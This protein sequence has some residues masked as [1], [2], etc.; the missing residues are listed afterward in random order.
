MTEDVVRHL[1]YLTLGTRLKR[2]GE[3]MQADVQR[4]LAAN[5]VGVPVAQFPFLAAIDRLGP[6]TIGELARAVG[7][8]QPG[9]TRAVEQLVAAELLVDQPS[10]SD[11]RRRTV[12]LTA[13]GKRLVG[14]A[15]RTVW[16]EI[17]HAVREL[18]HGLPGS[19]LDQL[20][21]IED[22]LVTEPLYRRTRKKQGRIG[23]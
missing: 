7:V 15:K 19:L 6:L 12:A 3:R 21:A 18:C 17:E 16:P 8:T 11:Q 4:I 20:E 13:Q 10:E 2:L 22:G 9:V 1:G 5:E 23:G 14:H